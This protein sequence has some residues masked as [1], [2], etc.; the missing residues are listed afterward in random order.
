M[1]DSILLN[2]QKTNNQKTNNQ[3]TQKSTVIN[4][5]A[6]ITY[7]IK[8]LQYYVYDVEQRIVLLEQLRNI[9]K[10]ILFTME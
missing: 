8:P 1:L 3:K 2:E 4:K 6:K 10:N 9:K 5:N 7:C